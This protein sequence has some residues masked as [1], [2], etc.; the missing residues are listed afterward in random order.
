MKLLV[1]FRFVRNVNH[2]DNSPLAYRVAVYF[3]CIA[4]I[5][6]YLLFLPPSFIVR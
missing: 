6:V 4:C 1:N 2:R 5:A 3:I